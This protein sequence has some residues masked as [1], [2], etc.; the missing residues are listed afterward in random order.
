MSVYVCVCES[1]CECVC[2]SV[3][4]CVCVYMCVL[5]SGAIP[6]KLS[7]YLFIYLFIYFLFCDRI[8]TPWDLGP[9]IHPSLLP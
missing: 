8:S 3:C 6:Q 1:V 2:V 9:E 4:E 5:N 7:I